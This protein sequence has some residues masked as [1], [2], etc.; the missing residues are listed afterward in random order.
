[1]GTPGDHLDALN[2]QGSFAVDL[3]MI[4]REMIGKPDGYCSCG[5]AELQRRPD[6]CNGESTRQMVLFGNPR[7]EPI[8]ENGLSL[9]SVYSR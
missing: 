7:P 5:G 8:R 1:M 2:S 4:L 9:L 3:D 6:G